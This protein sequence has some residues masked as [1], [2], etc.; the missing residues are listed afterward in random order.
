MTADGQLIEFQATAEHGTY[1]RAEMD[2]LT[3]LA[4]GGIRRL[5][6]IQREVLAAEGFTVLSE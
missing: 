1:T 2:A 3:D 6:A 5:L 4:A